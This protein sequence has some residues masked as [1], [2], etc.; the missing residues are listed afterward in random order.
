MTGY[1]GGERWGEPAMTAGPETSLSQPQGGTRDPAMC[2]GIDYDS[3][4]VTDASDH[5]AALGGESGP[6]DGADADAH[7]RDAGAAHPRCGRPRVDELPAW[8]LVWYARRGARCRPAL[9]PGGAAPEG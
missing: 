3:P 4:P 5:V 1:T 8:G 6:A 2:W 7:P 9:S